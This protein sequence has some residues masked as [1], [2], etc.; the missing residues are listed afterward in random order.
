MSI[1]SC[2]TGTACL[3]EATQAAKRVFALSGNCSSAEGRA[4]QISSSSRTKFF[5][6]MN[7]RPVSSNDSAGLFDLVCVGN[8]EKVAGQRI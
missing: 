8:Y 4:V 1:V 6:M 5:V 2:P 7:K 3:N